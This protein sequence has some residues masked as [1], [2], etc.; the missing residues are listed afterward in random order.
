MKLTR[1]IHFDGF[2]FVEMLVAIAVIAMLA[3]NFCDTSM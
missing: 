3:A 1:T 2:T